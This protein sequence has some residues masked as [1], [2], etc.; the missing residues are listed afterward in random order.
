M[1]S[2]IYEHN[3]DV[4]NFPGMSGNYAHAHTIFTRRYFSLDQRL[5]T[6]LGGEA[7]LDVG[8][9]RSVSLVNQT[10]FRER[11]CASERGEGKE[12]YGL[13]KLARFSKSRGMLR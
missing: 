8:G 13:A 7:T 11:A 10:V 4:C 6:R 2:R 9:A 12:K 1:T 5:G 3:A